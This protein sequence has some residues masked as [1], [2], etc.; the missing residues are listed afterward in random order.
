MS[1]RAI[2]PVVGASIGTVHADLSSGVQNRTPDA[3]PR[4]KTGLD[5]KTYTVQPR[6]PEPPHTVNTDT[7]EV[8]DKATG[9][10]ITRLPGQHPGP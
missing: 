7:G 9:E 4:T 2:A 5:G 6:K 1:S 8:I 10:V 3:E